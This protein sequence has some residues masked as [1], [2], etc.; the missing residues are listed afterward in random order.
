MKIIL[1]EFI[2]VRCNPENQVLCSYFIKTFL[3]WEYEKMELNFW[4][5][6]NLRECIKH[7]LVR[8]TKCIRVGVLRHYFIPR[9]NLLSI[10][11][12]RAA[13]CELLHLFDIIIESDIT[14]IKECKTL[15]TIWSEFLQVRENKNHVICK[16]RRRNLLMNDEC[17]ML[18]I[19]GIHRQHILGEENKRINPCFYDE[20][21]DHIRSLLCKTPLQNLV[22]ELFFFNRHL[23][24][25][26]N[27]EA[28]GS[29]NK[30][31]YKLLQTAKNDT[32]CY[33]L[34]TCKLWCA[35]LLY[36]KGD[37][38]SG[39]NIINQ[40]LSN[41]PPYA[42]H[43]LC[44]SNFASNEAKQLYMDMFLDSH[45]TIIQR[46]RKAWTLNLCIWENMAKV[47]PLAIQIELYFRPFYI[48][49]SPLSCIYYIQFLCYH[50]L[51]Q[52]GNRDRALQQLMDA[53]VYNKEECDCSYTSAL[54][55]A[56]HCLLLVGRIDQARDM[57]FQSYLITKEV[58]W[59]SSAQWYLQNFF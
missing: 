2:K 26:I 4:R 51:R 54:N 38:L 15:T 55:I 32:Y 53:L 20:I 31:L 13:Q 12:T 8:F 29:G 19:N 44:E 30:S 21:I 36:M 25:L 5:A 34:S 7:L 28:Y 50:E 41:I 58:S 18:N 17:M 42:M 16:L 6:D 37:Y 23:T 57:F 43:Q 47:V 40:V 48:T 10:K 39:L 3:F 59:P 49:L 52:Y 11:L 33:D 46:A 14:I 27:P 24:S 22:L 1:K 35:I 9:F 45:T 56:G